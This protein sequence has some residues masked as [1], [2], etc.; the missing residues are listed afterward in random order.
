M[1]LQ[2]KT[3]PQVPLYT[4]ALVRGDTIMMKKKLFPASALA[5]LAVWLGLN[6]FAQRG[7]AAGKAGDVAA[8]AD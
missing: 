8:A 6:T 7:P 4:R 2:A 5:L 3:N 1:A